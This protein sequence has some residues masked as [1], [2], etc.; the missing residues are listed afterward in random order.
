MRKQAG[1]LP[2]SHSL[3]FGQDIY[4]Q[5]NHPDISTKFGS[6]TKEDVQILN[7]VEKLHKIRDA[8]KHIE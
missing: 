3:Q 8:G 6:L 7:D 2:G 4:M 5:F 1:M